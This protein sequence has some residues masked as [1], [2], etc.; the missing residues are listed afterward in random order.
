MVPE[1]RDSFSSRKV[2]ASRDRIDHTASHAGFARFLLH[3]FRQV[4]LSAKEA[5][6]IGVGFGSWLRQA[7]GVTAVLHLL[8]ANDP[9]C[10]LV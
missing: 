4:D 6:C 9:N 8:Q 2:P 7:G 10:E 5:Y 1:T 3:P